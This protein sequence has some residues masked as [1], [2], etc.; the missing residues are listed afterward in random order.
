MAWF[1]EKPS[2]RYERLTEEKNRLEIQLNRLDLALSEIEK[3]RQ[4]RP[5]STLIKGLHRRV[6]ARQNEP[7]IEVA[8]VGGLFVSSRASSIP[9]PI[10]PP[11]F[12]IAPSPESICPRY[13]LR[14]RSILLCARLHRVAPRLQFLEWSV[15]L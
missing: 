12:V 5:I 2:T 11:F 15:L 6:C 9:A 7:R 4:L 10:S 1:P 13:R 8:S 14:C 3:L